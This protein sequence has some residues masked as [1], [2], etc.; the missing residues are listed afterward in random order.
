MNVSMRGSEEIT[1]PLSFRSPLSTDEEAR[2]RSYI[3]RQI[4][5]HR[6]NHTGLTI[7]KVD[8]RVWTALEPLLPQDNKLRYVRSLCL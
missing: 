7:N 2:F 6:S 3:L 8:K 5:K 4:A 1:P